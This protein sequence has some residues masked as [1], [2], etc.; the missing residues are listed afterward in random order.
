MCDGIASVMSYE[1]ATCPLPEKGNTQRIFP[2]NAIIGFDRSDNGKDNHQD[3]QYRCQK[4]PNEDKERQT[5]DQTVDKTT[6]DPIQGDLTMQINFG[7]FILAECPQNNRDNYSAR[8]RTK[9]Q[10][11]GQV[12]KHAVRIWFHAHYVC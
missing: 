8:R 11:L 10:Q 9:V 4:E 6:D 2:N 12:Q 5:N 1:K 3:H 7:A